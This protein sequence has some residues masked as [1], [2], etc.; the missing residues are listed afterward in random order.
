MDTQWSIGRKLA[1]GFGL[2]LVMLLTIGGVSYW[3][4]TVLFENAFWVTHTYQVL[5]NLEGILSLLKDTETGQRGFV[6]TRQERYLEPYTAAMSKLGPRIT[7]VR[8]LTSDNPK[9]KPRLDAL[10]TEIATR[11]EELQ[12][13]IALRRKDE[14]KDTI[15][16]QNAKGMEAALRIVLTDKG[17]KHMDKI[18]AI[19]RDMEDEENAL[20]KDRRET[21][22]R[23]VLTARLTIILGSLL[24]VVVLFAFSFVL[25][26]GITL[27]L[28]R[29]MARSRQIAD[30]DLKQE[31][32]AITSTDEVG[33]LTSGF[34]DMQE[35]LQELTRQA[36]GVTS[37][38]T[39][40]S[41]QIATAAQQQVTSLSQTGTALN[42]VT[43][44]AEEFKATMQ[45][46]ADR[47]RAVQEAADETTK[48]AHKGR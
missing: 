31:K 33:Q 34:N 2:A 6:L 41:A 28:Q 5:E 21:E 3:S 10:D 25:T 35:N 18:R 1:G 43:T 37:N 23:S 7:E 22:A 24:A 42:E 29:V 46:F 48:R 15:D 11:D 13:T 20:L 47:A 32:L 9:Q 38:L 27:P 36:A 12:E 39:T 8:K 16:L 19:V 14:A 30:G 17:K 26:R 44:T 45:E 40:A 4:L